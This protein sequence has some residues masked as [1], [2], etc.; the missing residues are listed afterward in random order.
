MVNNRVDIN[1]VLMQMRQVKDQ[2][3]TQH[4][5]STQTPEKM[6]ASQLQQVR[7]ARLEN[8][9]AA[10]QDTPEVGDTSVPNFQTMFK[11]AVNNVTEQQQVA[12]NPK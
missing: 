6:G 9:V 7:S 8:Q 11:N 10:V 5:Q 4:E 1:S 12:N 2:L 3:R